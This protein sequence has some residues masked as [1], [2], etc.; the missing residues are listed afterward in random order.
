MGSGR[1]K[2]PAAVPIDVFCPRRPEIEKERAFGDR[3]RQ[4]SRYRDATHS[5]GLI[6]QASRNREELTRKACDSARCS[7]ARA[8]E[9]R[10]PHLGEGIYPRNH[11][12]RSLQPGEVLTTGAIRSKAASRRKYLPRGAR[13]AKPAAQRNAQ[14]GE[15]PYCRCHGKRIPQLDKNT[16]V[17]RHLPAKFARSQKLPCKP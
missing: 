4:A 15:V 11:G 2:I 5:T 17:G 10:R 3:A 13:E 14:L 16:Q 6:Q 7:S 1:Y 9:K 12:K 8:R